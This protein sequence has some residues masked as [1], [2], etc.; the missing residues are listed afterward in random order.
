[1]ALKPP[2][3]NARYVLQGGVDEGDE[4]KKTADE[5]VIRTSGKAESTAWQD[6]RCV[7]GKERKKNV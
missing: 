5:H 7:Y 6:A 1:M 3:T 4:K 2:G